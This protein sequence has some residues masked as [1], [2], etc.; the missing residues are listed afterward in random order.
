VR[1]LA[2]GLLRFRRDNLMLI[3]TGPTRDVFPGRHT[4]GPTKPLA[5]RHGRIES[6][7]TSW[8]KTRQPAGFSFSAMSAVARLNNLDTDGPFSGPF[9]AIKKA[10]S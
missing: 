5:Q 2:L 3:R 8:Q 1:L 4:S 9:A 10:Q 6:M 7:R